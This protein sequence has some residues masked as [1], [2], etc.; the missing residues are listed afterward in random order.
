VCLMDADTV[1][2]TAIVTEA[3]DS[4]CLAIGSPTLN[5]GILP[6]MAS[7]LTYLRGLRPTGRSG[8]AFGSYGWA[9]RGIDELVQYLQAMQVTPVRDPISCRFRPD[10][11][12]LQLFRE[13]G[14]Q[15]AAIAREKAAGA[16]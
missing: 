3:L 10:A 8:L 6:R 5:Q 7:T 11:A 2:D 13:T 9:P 14:R 16:G 1:H 15:L 4:A 12:T